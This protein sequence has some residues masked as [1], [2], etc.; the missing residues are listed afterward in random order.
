MRILTGRS[1]L[2]ALTATVSLAL[3]LPP[4]AFAQNGGAPQPAPAN[5]P[6]RFPMTIDPDPRV[7]QESYTF[8]PTGEE[9]KYTLYVSSKVKP[10]VPAPLIVALHG[11][12]GDSN[13]ILRG[14][15]V[16]LA[17]AGG[18]IVV[19]PMGYN[20]VG[21]YGSP[22]IVMDGGS[23]KPAN[24]A[25]L[26]E[27]DVMTVMEIAR[28]KYNIDPN[29]TYLMGHSMGGAGTIYLGQKHADVWA[30]AAAMAPAAFM[31]QPNATKVLAPYKD[32]QLPLMILEGTADNV[33]PPNSARA[34]SAAMDEVGLP[35]E[36]IEKDGLDHGTIIGGSMDDIFRFFGEHTRTPPPPPPFR[37]GGRPP[38]N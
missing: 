1:G 12:G 10:D 25:G 35:H 13:F 29:R 27:L 17:E 34:W 11:M 2:L 37:P 26:S 5:G 14:K 19:A 20:T 38:S 4:A 8:A 16:D 32:A 23:P 3:A 36:Y 6:P 9:M 30:A 18:Y 31:M 22:V 21:W 24:L 7:K 28:S 33:V 15:L